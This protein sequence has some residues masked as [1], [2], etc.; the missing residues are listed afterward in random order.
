MSK[1]IG[2]LALKNYI[3]TN[4]I[5]SNLCVPIGIHYNTSSNDK[6]VNYEIKNNSKIMND[7]LFNNILNLVKVSKFK[8]SK[9][10]KIKIGKKTRKRKNI[11]L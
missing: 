5:L 1:Q 4:N 2:G 8:Y 10:N 7:S 9:K 3:N 11:K 6:I